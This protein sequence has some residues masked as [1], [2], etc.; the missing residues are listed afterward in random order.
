MFTGMGASPSIP[1]IGVSPGLLLWVV[2][3]NRR[4]H[5]LTLQGIPGPALATFTAQMGYMFVCI[6]PFYL[7]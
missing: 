7:P 2:A 3:E 1:F 6:Q 5:S 4:Q